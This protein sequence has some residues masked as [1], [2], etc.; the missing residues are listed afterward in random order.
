M[1]ANIA[2]RINHF[3]QGTII[4]SISYIIS[5]W[6]FLLLVFS[7]ITRSILRKPTNKLSY[8]YAL[9]IGVILFYGINEIFFK[10]ILVEYSGIRLRPYISN[11]ESIYAIG[12]AFVD[13]SFP[14]SHMASTSLIVSLW[15]WKSPKFWWIALIIALL[16]GISRI[17]N[18]MHYP[19]DVLAGAILGIIYAVWWIYISKKLLYKRPSL[20]ILFKNH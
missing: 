3:G 20:R 19:S 9:C 13:S 12:K 6:P 10:D 5:R 2:L 14:S 15:V 4:D 1:D 16:V 7:A 11:P 8:V 18:G 17:H